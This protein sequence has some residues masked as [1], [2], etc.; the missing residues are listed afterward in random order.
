MT[1]PRPCRPGVSGPRVQAGRMIVG[2][3]RGAVGGAVGGSGVVIRSVPGSR[4]TITRTGVGWGR[5]A[6]P[7]P[8]VTGPRPCRPGV[9]GPRVPVGRMIVGGG[10]GAVGGAVGGSRGGD[11]VRSGF[12]DDD[13]R[14]RGGVGRGAG[15]FPAVTGPRPCRPGGVRA[16]SPGWP[17]DRR[18]G[19][20][21]RGWCGSSFRDGDQDRDPG[22]HKWLDHPAAGFGAH[23]ARSGGGRSRCC[24]ER[25]TGCSP[26]GRGTVRRAPW[27]DGLIGGNLGP[28]AVRASVP[29]GD[30]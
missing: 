30:R 1:G 17:D 3:G 7:F 12:P 26:N 22:F 25:H 19:T 4:T 18:W 2:G 27:R 29:F 5:G 28:Y 23:R 9:S 16:A 21:S 14:Y 20:W 6:G 11:Q 10:R 8:A 13:H 15:P 24:A